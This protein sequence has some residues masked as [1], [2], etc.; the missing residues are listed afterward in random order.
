MMKTILIVLLLAST[1]LADRRDYF[2]VSE[3]ETI[4]AAA[5]RNGCKGDLFIILLAI[6]K[7]ESGS[8]GKEFGIL[9]PKA[10]D[11]NL[12]T[13]AGWAAAT[14]VKNHKRW[15]DA[16]KPESFVSFLSKRYCPIGADNDPNGLN[17]H[18]RKNVSHWCRRLR[19]EQ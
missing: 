9:H 11:T 17:R 15:L 14:V 7:A 13:Q 1:A 3:Y 5:D 6:R 4:K 8:A 2:S 16:G 19:Y 18:W 10:V 12:D